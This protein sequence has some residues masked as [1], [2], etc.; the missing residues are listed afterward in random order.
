[1]E[2]ARTE[3]EA[4]LRGASE[5]RARL[6]KPRPRRSATGA[7]PS[8]EARRNSSARTRAVPGRGGG[9]EEK[10]GGGRGAKGEVAERWRR[11]RAGPPGGGETE[12]AVKKTARSRRGTSWR[13]SAKIAGRRSRSSARRCVREGRDGV[14]EGRAG[15]REGRARG[16]SRGQVL[17][18]E[19]KSALGGTK[20]SLGRRTRLEQIRDA[21]SSEAKELLDDLGSPSADAG[22]QGGARGVA[23]APGVGA[24][25]EEQLLDVEEE[26]REAK[27]ALEA[28]LADASRVPGRR[29]SR[30]G[31]RS[32][33]R[34]S[35]TPRRRW[36]RR[37]GRARRGVE[38]RG[39]SVRV[40]ARRL[41]LRFRR[42]TR[43]FPRRRSGGAPRRARFAR[44]SPRRRRRWRRRRTPSPSSR[45]VMRSGTTRSSAS[46]RRRTTRRCGAWRR[47]CARSRRRCRARN[48]SLAKTRIA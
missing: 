43:R 22:G 27:A 38:P 31:W 8:A 23:R 47:T 7:T 45:N 30:S 32:P 17:A 44:R 20:E 10:L 19:T 24:A 9:G 37:S 5:L 15:H 18:D 36:R 26:L 25:D 1:M 29:R 28:A 16:G 42:R 46:S 14:G 33:R 12:L 39:G 11:S 40:R 2:D 6:T 41:G 34:R 35:R 21:A 4:A 13:R 3:L 48:P